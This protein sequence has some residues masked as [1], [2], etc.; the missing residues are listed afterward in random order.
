MLTHLDLC[1]GI[2]SSSIAAEWA[3]I[4]TIGMAEINDFP[5]NILCRHWPDIPKWRN[6]KNVNRS[7]IR[8]AGIDQVDI[9]SGGIPCQPFSING[10]RMGTYDE[11]NLWGNMRKTIRSILPRWIVLENVPG[12]L[13]IDS[14]RFFRGVLSDMAKMGYLVGW[15]CWK[16]AHAGAP[17]HRERIFVIGYHWKPK[18]DPNSYSFY[19]YYDRLNAS[20]IRWKQQQTSHLWNS[21]RTGTC[22][23]SEPRVDRVAHGI[24]NQLDR[25]EV[26]GNSIVPQQIYPIYNWIAHWDLTMLNETEY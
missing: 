22:W 23:N 8:K 21:E 12:I 18:A 7:T 10:K 5:Y 16:A 24:T 4:E 15:G 2:G 3:G 13:S 11:R 6:V 20:Q 9:I 1:T 25:L 26:I 17:H 14:G 19:D